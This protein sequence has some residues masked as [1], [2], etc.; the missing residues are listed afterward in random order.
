MKFVSIRKDYSHRM[1]IQITNHPF[2]WLRLCEMSTH[3]IQQKLVFLQRKF[4]SKFLC[5]HPKV[6]QL[7]EEG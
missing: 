6:V 3:K 5:F 7:S 4:Y 1:S 2:V